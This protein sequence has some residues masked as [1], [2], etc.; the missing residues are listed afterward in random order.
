[1]VA[2]VIG[3][4]A[5]KVLATILKPSGMIHPRKKD[6]DENDETP[7]GP[8]TE[9]GATVDPEYVLHVESG[10]DV[11]DEVCPMTWIAA[12]LKTSA[13]P[14]M[15]TFVRTDVPM[16]CTFASCHAVPSW[17]TTHDMVS[18]VSGIE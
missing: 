8:A 2:I 13:E 12:R 1:M 9:V 15:A 11:G 6:V 16:C 3:V 10:N 4:V 18:P 7:L 5:V 17:T 14:S